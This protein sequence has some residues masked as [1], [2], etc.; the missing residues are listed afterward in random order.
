[1][2]VHAM[3]TSHKEPQEKNKRNMWKF[4]ELFTKL[5]RCNIDLLT[6]LWLVA[7]FETNNQASDE[8]WS[9][10]LDLG[11]AFIL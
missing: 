4:Y 9:A 8:L 10:D 6:S 1:M 7:V 3:E 11:D 5:N 2:S